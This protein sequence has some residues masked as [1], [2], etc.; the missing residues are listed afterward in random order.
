MLHSRYSDLFY[1]SVASACATFD[2][3]YTLCYFKRLNNISKILP[4][5]GSTGLSQRLNTALYNPD[6]A[7][8]DKNIK[9]AKLSIQSLQL[10][11]E[12]PLGGDP[13][14]LHSLFRILSR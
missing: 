6:S 7:V 9:L 2:G 12:K 8:I 1:T 5:V 11:H 4:S 14:V 10:G 3:F 13:H